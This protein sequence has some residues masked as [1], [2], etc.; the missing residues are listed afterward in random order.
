M[1]FLIESI[2]HRDGQAHVLILVV[3]VVTVL[4]VIA[5]VVITCWIMKRKV[6]H[7]PGTFFHFIMTNEIHFYKSKSIQF[8]IF[9][10]FSPV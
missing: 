4:I 2:F 10:Y 1:F 8:Y 7:F 9:I 3:I 5:V 6:Q